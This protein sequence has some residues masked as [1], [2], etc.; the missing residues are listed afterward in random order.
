MVSAIASGSTVSSCCTAR[1]LRAILDQGTTMAESD[2]EGERTVL[3]SRPPGAS[4]ISLVFLLG[5]A[6]AVALVF[7]FF[8]VTHPHLLSPSQGA[9]FWIRIAVL[10]V[11]GVGGVFTAAA[12]VRI[13]LR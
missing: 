2:R 10:A 13:V 9:L 7:R 12:V 4:L 6:L 3:A 1:P 11:V 5:L 8:L